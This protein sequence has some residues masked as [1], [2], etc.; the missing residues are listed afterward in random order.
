MCVRSCGRTRRRGFSLRSASAR[1]GQSAM[2][3]VHL[4]GS[5][6]L[7][8]TPPRTFLGAAAGVGLGLTCGTLP[9]RAAVPP[10]LV[11]LVRLLL[12]LLLATAAPYT[13]PPTT[14]NDQLLT[15]GR[16]PWRTRPR[17]T[18]GT[19]RPGTRCRGRHRTF[20]GERGRLHPP[21]PS[22][23]C[24]LG[25]CLRQ[26]PCEGTGTERHPWAGGSLVGW[27]R[28]RCAVRVKCGQS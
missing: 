15:T 27:G 16:R 10:G 12:L 3:V 25:I 21:V 18:R 4:A 23:I 17:L 28:R 13:D 6:A 1:S 11:L 5:W 2:P 9:G 19:C 14:A 8:T 24:L 26:R 22:T 7:G 20:T